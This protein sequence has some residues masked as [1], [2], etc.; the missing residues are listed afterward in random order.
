[1]V[2]QVVDLVITV[3]QCSSIVWLRLWIL[4]KCDRIIVVR[5]LAYRFFRLDVDR[6]SLRR[7][8]GAEGL[9]LAIVKARGA[10]KAGEVNGCWG[11]TMESR[12][13]AN[14]IVPPGSRQRKCSI[15]P[16]IDQLTSRASP[17]QLR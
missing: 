10:A 5:D 16:A 3:D 15:N 12:E 1:M 4:E 11:D 17:A 13:C 7:G 6:F 14:G 2:D 9:D 8:D